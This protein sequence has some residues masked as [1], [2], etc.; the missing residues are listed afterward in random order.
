MDFMSALDTRRTDIEKPRTLPQGTY[1][2]SVTKFKIGTVNSAKGDWDVVEFL[3]RAVQAHEDVDPEELE[4]FG[5]LKNAVNRV[6]FMFTKAADGEN[7]RIL[8]QNRMDK[9]LAEILAVDGHDDPDITLKAMVAAAPNC[10]FV[11]RAVWRVVDDN[12]YV[13]LK[14]M[15][16]LE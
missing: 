1:T 10:Q 9:F 14:D 13:D 5:D 12:T 4:A 3:V 7:E 16:P 6:S 8:T 2:W 11:S 15:M